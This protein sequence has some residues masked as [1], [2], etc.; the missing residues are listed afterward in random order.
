MLV[1]R[2]PNQFRARN[3]PVTRV[4]F[5]N[6]NTYCLLVTKTFVT[7]M[8]DQSVVRL[9]EFV[10]IQPADIGWPTGNGKKLNRSQAQL[11]QATGLAVAY[12]LSISC[13]PSYVYSCKSNKN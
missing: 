10:L 3:V 11:A 5:Q 12:F 2:L 4:P 9:N 6:W 8:L 7:G 13:G 1:P